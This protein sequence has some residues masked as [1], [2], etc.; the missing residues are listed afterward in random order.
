MSNGPIPI[1]KQ[2]QPP[3][4]PHC[5]RELELNTGETS[6]TSGHVA[7]VFFCNLCGKTISVQLIGQKKKPQPS[8]LVARPRPGMKM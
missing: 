4:C 8:I 3:F 2:P 6:F 1:I 5:D 7:Q